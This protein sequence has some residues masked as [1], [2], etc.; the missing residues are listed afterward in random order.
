MIKRADNNNIF[1]PGYMNIFEKNDIMVIVGE[2]ALYD[3]FPFQYAKVASRSPESVSDQHFVQGGSIP[4]RIPFTIKMKLSKFVALEDIPHIVMQREWKNKKEVI[5]PQIEGDWFVAHF[6]EFGNFQ[7]IM[8]KAAPSIN[9]NFSEQANLSQ[10]SKIV[11]NISDNNKAI[12]NFN[13]ELNGN[14]LRFSNDK[15]RSFIYIFDEM[16]RR[17]ENELRVHVEDESGNATEK[18]FHFTK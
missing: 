4:L 5:K 6:R 3:S 13:A 10:V 16:C 2:K 1:H 9:V 12:K 18:L 17:G 15:G 8:D 11:V 14:W 7:L